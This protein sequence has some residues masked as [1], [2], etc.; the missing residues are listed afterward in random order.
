MKQILIHGCALLIILTGCN[1]PLRDRHLKEY[2]TENDIVDQ[3]RL[4]PASLDLLA[5]DGFKSSN[6]PQHRIVFHADGTCDFNTV[7][8]DSNGLA[9]YEVSGKWVLEKDSKGDSN[10]Q[11]KNALRMELKL[12]TKTYFKYLNFDR[13]GKQLILWSFHGDPDSWEFMEYER[14]P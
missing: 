13:R 14:V 1:S 3:W 5:R 4:M 8:D 12:P 6:N 11:C 7:L 9:Y 2:V 10:I